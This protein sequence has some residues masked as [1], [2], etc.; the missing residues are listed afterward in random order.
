[1]IKDTIGVDISKDHLDAHRVSDGAAR[2]FANDTAGHSAFVDWLGQAGA[3]STPFRLDGCPT[4]LA[5][6]GS[7]S[8]VI[9]N[10]L[11]VAASYATAATCR[12]KSSIVRPAAG[13][14]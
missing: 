4:K 13:E 7:V 14:Y 2:R 3:A 10:I 5:E 6:V 12:S 8:G 9:A 1:M 11:S